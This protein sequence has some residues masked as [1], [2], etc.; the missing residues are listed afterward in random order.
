MRI[1][2]IFQNTLFTHFLGIQYMCLILWE[3]PSPKTY[4]LKKHNP[5]IEFCENTFNYEK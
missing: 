2:S 5:H 3:Y 4:P 1:T